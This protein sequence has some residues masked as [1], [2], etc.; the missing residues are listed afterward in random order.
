MDFRSFN[1]GLK[2]LYKI[3]IFKY[4]L[5]K[6]ELWTNIDSALFQF[7]YIVVSFT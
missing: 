3:S 5:C 1:N 4:L 7:L 2:Q 6:N